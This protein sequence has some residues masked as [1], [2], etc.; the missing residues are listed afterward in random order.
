MYMCMYIIIITGHIITVVVVIAERNNRE[1][2][3]IIITNSS[4][5]K[6]VRPVNT[7]NLTTCYWENC[8]LYTMSLQEL[9]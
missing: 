6:G 5:D 3:I 2:I 1:I 9:S 8:T 4:C 7:N